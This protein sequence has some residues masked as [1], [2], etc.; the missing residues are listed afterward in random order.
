[1]TGVLL[2]STDKTVQYK[3]VQTRNL[4]G[5]ILFLWDRWNSALL[6]VPGRCKQ[7]R[8]MSASQCSCPVQE[9]AGQEPCSWVTAARRRDT[10]KKAQEEHLAPC[11]LGEQQWRGK[12]NGQGVQVGANAEHRLGCVWVWVGSE[13]DE[14]FFSPKFPSSKAS[15][16]RLAPQRRN[17]SSLSI[18]LPFTPSWSS[19]F[20]NSQTDTESSTAAAVWRRRQMH[21]AAIELQPQGGAGSGLDASVSV[22]TPVGR[23]LFGELELLVSQLKASQP[24]SQQM[25]TAGGKNY[26]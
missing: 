10:H 19:P 26:S 23:V 3:E 13:T 16:S 6:A 7:T 1:M 11:V 4:T 5:L 22:C 2:Y 8:V 9:Q 12:V 18:G 17:S 25:M 14:A 20:V 24:V 21:T 15:L